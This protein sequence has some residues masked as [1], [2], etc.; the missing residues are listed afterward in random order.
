MFASQTNDL[1]RLLESEVFE[2][3]KLNTGIHSECS[4]MH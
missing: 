2:V 4:L 1:D 3:I